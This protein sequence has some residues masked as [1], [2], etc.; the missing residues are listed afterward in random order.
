MLAGSLA[1]VAFAQAPLPAPEAPSVAPQPPAGPAPTKIGI[2][3]VQNAILSTKEGQKATGDLNT[4]FAP[5]KAKF[6]KDQADIQAL[7]EQMRKGSATMSDDARVKLQ[8][9][10]DQ[11]QTAFKRN[12]EDAQ[13]ELD[14]V[15]GKMFQDLGVKLQE[16][17]QQYAMQK[18]LAIV[19]DVSNQQ[20]T[21]VFW[22]AASVDI[23]TDVIRLYDQA[24]PGTAAP[25]A[26][27]SPP[28]KKN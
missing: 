9:D 21:P 15:E 18:G 1:L 5:T 11:K 4:R 14:Q 7:V 23:T 28:A 22:A 24:H 27:P 3:H 12:Q 19:I 26:Q 20:T 25:A 17:L 16:V 13:A 6:D 10:I 8:R 2:I